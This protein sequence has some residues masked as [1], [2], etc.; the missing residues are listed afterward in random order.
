MNKK[1]TLPYFFLACFMT[2]LSCHGIDKKNSEDYT[3]K[4]TTR[5][6]DSIVQT[7]GLLIIASFDDT[8][9]IDLYRGSQENKA[10]VGP[11]DFAGSGNQIWYIEK[12]DQG[13]II[14]SNF[15]KKVLAINLENSILVQQDFK[16]QDN[17]LWFISGKTDSVR[18]LNK[19]LN[20]YLTLGSNNIICEESSNKGTQSWKFKLYQKIVGEIVSCNCIENFEFIRNRIETSYS[21]F[22]DKVN[23]ST[24]AEYDKL[25]AQSEKIIRGTR[26]TAFCFKTIHH[27]LSFFN[28]KHIHFNMNNN[29]S[30]VC[31]EKDSINVR[32]FY[33][34]SE[35]VHM[36][37]NEATLYYKSNITKLSAL[38][39]IWESVAG[40]YRCAIIKDR[41]DNNHFKGIILKANISSWSPGQVKMDFRKTVNNKYTL[42]YYMGNHSV[43]TNENMEYASGDTLYT[44]M[45]KWIK[46]FPKSPV[47]ARRVVTMSQSKKADWFQLKNIDDSTLLLSLPSFDGNNKTLVDNLLQNNKSK[48]LNTPYLI[49]DVCGNGGGTDGTFNSILPFLYTNPFEV[50]GN[51]ILAS[52]ENTAWFEKQLS[53]PGINNK[54][55]FQSI[56]KRMKENPGKF[57]TYAGGGPVR[58][59]TVLT[60]P[61]KIAIL[62]NGNCASSTEQFLLF[63]RESKKVKLFGQPTSG[64]LDY[65]NVIEVDCP[66]LAFKF[67]YATTKTR[68][69][70][71]FSVDKEKIKP[72]VYFTNDINWIDQAAKQLKSGNP[73]TLK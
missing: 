40:D 47:A 4:N 43:I 49:I 5:E 62:I 51:D 50:V 30:Y 8:K 57:V 10:T 45:G 17:Q 53:K 60:N 1:L 59:D 3:K 31:D 16:E 70:P 55:W 12:T 71:N 28:D 35:S 44:S 41:A 34:N 48:L 38:E 72:D 37:E 58:Y 27:Y 21:G 6:L 26:N 67:G 54:E 7:H 15:S 52:K 42:Y 61:R 25:C 69:L 65:S 56:V 36:K 20:K 32:T 22:Q 13:Y 19:G 2:S 66:S 33:A 39:G 64:T 23:P 24:K 73:I 14:R 9:V 29:L 63:A 11:Y 18:L 68:R 46:R